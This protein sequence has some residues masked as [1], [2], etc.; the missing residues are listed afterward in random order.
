M[1][2]EQIRDLA[3]RAF[4][5]DTTTHE[6]EEDLGGGQWRYTVAVPGKTDAIFVVDTNTGGIH[7][8]EQTPE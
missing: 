4:G 2:K 3:G 5:A 8:I 1:S 7:A 6:T